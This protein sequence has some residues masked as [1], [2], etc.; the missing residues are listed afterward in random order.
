MDFIDQVS[1][2]SQQV[3][4]LRESVKTEQATKNVLTSFQE[5]RASLVISEM[6][7]LAS[8]MSLVIEIIQLACKSDSL[9]EQ[10][11]LIVQA[12]DTINQINFVCDNEQS[13][14]STL[15]TIDMS[16]ENLQLNMSYFAAK[17]ISLND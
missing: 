8:L 5:V 16:Y 17:E 6:H 13:S 2:I 15:E 14:T 9:Q 10:N 11:L 12:L 4:K 1:T 3:Q 7:D